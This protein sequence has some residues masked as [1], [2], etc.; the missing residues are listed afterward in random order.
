MFVALARCLVM[1]RY[2]RRLFQ[3]DD[4]VVRERFIHWY[5]AVN[6]IASS[7]KISTCHTITVTCKHTSQNGD[8]QARRDVVDRGEDQRRWRGA[9]VVLERHKQ[10]SARVRVPLARIALP[11]QPVTFTVAQASS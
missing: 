9:A 7:N 3:Y 1:R 5:L 11:Q 2:V 4:I 6:V 8:R 10:A